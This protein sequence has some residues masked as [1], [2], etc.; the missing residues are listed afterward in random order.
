ML[1]VWARLP[2]QR[3]QLLICS[4]GSRSNSSKRNIAEPIEISVSND[5]QST[6][7]KFKEVVRALNE[8]IKYSRENNSIN[9][10]IGQDGE[11][12]NFYGSL[13]QTRVD[14]SAVSSLRTVLSGIN[15]EVDGSEI[16]ILADLG[17]KNANRDLRRFYRRPSRRGRR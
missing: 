16:R 5:T 9:S 10:E 2:A 7:D 6:L 13:A 11:V 4:Q 8:V 3:I 12:D 14:D 1:P 17:L 15:S